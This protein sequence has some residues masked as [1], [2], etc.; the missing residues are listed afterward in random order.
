MNNQAIP[1]YTNNSL[2][3]GRQYS[4]IIIDNTYF[5]VGEEFKVVNDHGAVRAT[6]KIVNVE[7]TN[8]DRLGYE[9]LKNAASPHMQSWPNAVEYFLK[10][11][12]PTFTYN[13]PVQLVTY[14]ILSNMQ[15][16]TPL[17]ESVKDE[18]E[19]NLPT[20]EELGIKDESDDASVSYIVEE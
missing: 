4:S 16:D 11:I 9:Q 12:G 10:K 2:E 14:E 3:V 15:F 13:G 6:A 20:D 8:F 1:A 18:V 19:L 5:P 17:I 7:E